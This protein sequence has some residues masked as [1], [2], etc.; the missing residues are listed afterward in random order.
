MSLG[1]RGV[2]K[3]RGGYDKKQRAAWGG[4]RGVFRG[5]FGLIGW[6]Y[7]LRSAT[8]GVIF[9]VFCAI[10]SVWRLQF[11]S[12]RAFGRGRFSRKPGRESA[13]ALLENLRR[14]AMHSPAYPRLSPPLTTRRRSS[15]AWCSSSPPGGARRWRVKIPRD[16]FPCGV[17]VADFLRTPSTLRDRDG[18]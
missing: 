6:R 17:R 12:L 16:G 10:P 13:A 4:L 18:R 5:D 14:G 9:P 8:G 2:K 7:T 1:A 11:H 15:L 3:S